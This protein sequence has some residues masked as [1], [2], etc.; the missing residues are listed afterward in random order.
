MVN[1]IMVARLLSETPDLNDKPCQQLSL[2]HQ[3]SLLISKVVATLTFL[4]HK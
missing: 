3:Y 4:E 2:K 1:P